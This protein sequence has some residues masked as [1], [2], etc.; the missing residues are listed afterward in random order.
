MRRRAL[1]DDALVEYRDAVAH[2]QRLGL[3]VGDVDHRE[4]ELV[5]QALDLELHLFAQLLVQGAER[6]VHQHDVRREDQCAG[7]CHPLPL[8]AGELA[9]IAVAEVLQLDQGQVLVDLGVDLFPG[10]LADLQRVGEVLADGHVRKQCVLLEHHA[11]VALVGRDAGDLAAVDQDLS[12]GHVLEAGEHHQAGGLSGT[13]R[14]EQGDELALGHIQIEVLDHQRLVVVGLLHVGESQERLVLGLYRHT[15]PLTLWPRGL[16]LAVG[17]SVPFRSLGQPVCSRQAVSRTSYSLAQG[18]RSPSFLRRVVTPG[19]RCARQSGARRWREV[20]EGGCPPAVCMA[21]W[22]AGGR[23]AS[24]RAGADGAS[25]LL[26]SSR[27][28]RLL[29]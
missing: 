5:V 17:A 19:S 13:G 23:G 4:A 16:R 6:F 29:M 25:Q 20:R 24:H 8:A 2:G 15:P 12:A 9:G 11:D 7:Q 26:G 10:L 18:G 1:L 28:V 3:V 21:L 27:Q 22:T 14:A